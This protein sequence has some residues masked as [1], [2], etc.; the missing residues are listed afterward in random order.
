VWVAVGDGS[1]RRVV[2]PT[3]PLSVAVPSGSR[4]IDITA[5]AESHARVDLSGLPD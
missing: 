4:G 2:G 5:S 3:K 1:V